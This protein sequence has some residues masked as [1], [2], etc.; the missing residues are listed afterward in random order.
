MQAAGISEE[1]YNQRT[2]FLDFLYGE[3]ERDTQHAARGLHRKHPRA[4]FML[5]TRP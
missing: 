2:E 1:T 5:R 3:F 4:I